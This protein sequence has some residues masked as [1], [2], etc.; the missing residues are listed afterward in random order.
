MSTVVSM[1]E[2]RRDHERLRIGHDFT[3][4]VCHES[5][6][7]RLLPKLLDSVFELVGVNRGAICL[8]DQA[9]E[10]AP[11]FVKT[12]EPVPEHGMVLSKTII[13][14]VLE[15]GDVVVSSNLHKDKRFSSAHSVIIKNIRAVIAGPLLHQ[16]EI[17]GIVYADSQAAAMGAIT[18]KDAE[19]FASMLGQTA[20]R[21]WQ[22]MLLARAQRQ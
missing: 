3:R 22:A 21:I 2:L 16:D 18:D 9:G 11:R 4:A 12:R 19:V 5:D 14:E 1:E 20:L 8:M 13:D 17:L 6:L 7:E 10:L 15:H